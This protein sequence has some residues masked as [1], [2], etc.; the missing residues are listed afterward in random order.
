M[1]GEEKVYGLVA[2]WSA[3]LYSECGRRRKARQRRHWW[4]LAHKHH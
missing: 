1:T 3:A 4:K 2:L